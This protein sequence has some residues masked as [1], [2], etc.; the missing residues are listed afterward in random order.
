LIRHGNEGGG[1]APFLRRE[2]V[3]GAAGGAGVHRLRDHAGGAQ[4][5]AQ[6]LREQRHAAAAADEQ[7]LDDAGRAGANDLVERLDRDRFD[8]G[9]RPGCGTVGNTRI[10]PW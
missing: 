3:V 8:V 2:H 1:D 10:E 4:R 9:H 5:P 6:G 7:N